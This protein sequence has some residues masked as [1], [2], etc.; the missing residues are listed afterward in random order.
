MAY[1]RFL[2]W[3]LC[4]LIYMHTHCFSHHWYTRT[5]ATWS[6]WLPSIE[7]TYITFSQV[8]IWSF[9]FSIYFMTSM[10]SVGFLVSFTIFICVFL[11]WHS[12]TT[13]D[14]TISQNTTLMYDFVSQILLKFWEVAKKRLYHNV[15]QRT[16]YII[17]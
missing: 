9:H 15:A 4:S 6:A 11:F 5:I 1:L 8:Q 17:W 2:L 13:L 16:I 3:S 14:A 7:I 12:C 10:F